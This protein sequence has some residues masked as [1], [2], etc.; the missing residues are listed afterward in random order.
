MRSDLRTTVSFASDTDLRDATTD[1]EEVRSQLR[2][3]VRSHRELQREL[4]ELYTSRSWRLTAPLRRI[5]QRILRAQREQQRVFT[6][7]K[8]TV[9]RATGWLTE[10][11]PLFRR[12]QSRALEIECQ[13]RGLAIQPNTYVLYRIIGND[14]YPRH[15]RGQSREN[16]K[17]ILDNEPALEACEKR[18][19]VNRIVDVRE[20]AAII[21]LLEERGQTYL[22]IP[23][24]MEEYK[25]VSWDFQRFP[26]G[27]FLRGDYLRRGAYERLR[28]EVAAC[29][30]KNNYIM[31]NNGARNAALRDGRR[32]AKWVLP[33]D[34]N[35]FV[36]KSGWAALT[37]SISN[38]PHLKYFW[39]P[40]A[41]ILDN[42]SL[43]D[44]DFLP[45][46]TEEPQLVFRRDAEEEFNEEFPYGRRPKVELLWRLGISGDWDSWPDDAWDLPR[47][48]RCK[49]SG[50]VEEAGWV[51][52]LFSGMADLE[53]TTKSSLVGRG[54]A[55]VEAI[56]ATIND[57]DERVV[58]SSTDPQR[59][60]AYD[61]AAIDALRYT[62][63]KSAEE[64]LLGH[65]TEMA[66]LALQRGPYSVVDKL[67]LPPSGNPHDY[68]HPA[69]YW[70]P[71]P[72]SEDGLPY[73]WRDGQR[74]PGTTL[75]EPDSELYDR[76][77][78]QRL[79]DDTTVLA[80]AWRATGRTQYAEHGA[81]LL[82]RWFIDP[83]SRMTPNL[84]YAQVQRGH[85]FDE[86]QSNGIIEM[87]DMYFFLD[88][89][90]I[91]CRAGV[92]DESEQHKLKIWLRRYLDW[93]L[94]SLQGLGE[95]DARNN[96]GTCYDLQVA[97]IAAYLGDF[98]QLHFTFRDSHER[99]LDQFDVDGRQPHEMQRTL[100]AHY[101]CFNLQ[102]WVNLA[103]LAE[104]CGQ[105]LWNG[106]TSSGQRL[107]KGFEWVA[108]FIAGSAWR[109]PQLETF[110]KSRYLPLYFACRER[111]RLPDALHAVEV[112]HRLSMKPVFFS[113]DG[114]KPFWML[115][116]QT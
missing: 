67:S 97:A 18:W 91:L 110:D 25:R 12:M 107:G 61:E 113:H 33:W 69:P 42:Q 77:R 16:V 28:A 57:V 65:L 82:T 63:K 90:R 10:R 71:N 3:V 59:L 13:K 89:V 36:T 2:S 51:A 34:G 58:Q 116:A 95:H 70:W 104:R 55:R 56:T 47:P 87:K 17:F 64:K 26:R 49:R 60:L 84:R 5:L 31:N 48:R 78:L 96:H 79:F 72:C 93:L 106:V 20:E 86:G 40:M 32:R 11:N 27:F 14:L 1:L 4:Q 73:V 23:F 6:F 80:L 66:D 30:L 101:V 98:K 102:S 44:P 50:L 88:A 99:I 85:N 92:L 109:W 94:E 105:N 68:W 114:I 22:R 115:E 15:R 74:V 21:S 100:T 83:E 9:T 53:T 19:V 41:R 112:P 43:L 35:C 39:V 54:V 29:R 37:K 52:R 8:R 38:Q 62:Q 46:V 111:F 75:Y 108:P 45:E 76:T 7:T 24:D 81:K 103:I